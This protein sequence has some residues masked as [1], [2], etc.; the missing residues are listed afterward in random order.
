MPHKNSE[1]S[2][3]SFMLRDS[4]LHIIG[5]LVRAFAVRSNLQPIGTDSHTSAG[6]E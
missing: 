6:R 1:D 3:A 2:S 5:D 4:R